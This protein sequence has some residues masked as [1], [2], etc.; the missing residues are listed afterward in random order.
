MGNSS[1][2]RV[3]DGGVHRKNQERPRAFGP[4]GE[5]LVN[6]VER[7]GELNRESAQTDS[8]LK[9]RVVNLLRNNY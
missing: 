5:R 9:L 8:G 2:W 6:V 1:K 4:M 7:T 3:G